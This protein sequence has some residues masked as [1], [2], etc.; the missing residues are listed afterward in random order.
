M[1][2]LYGVVGE[3]MGHAMRSA[4]LLEALTQAGHELRIVGSGRAAAYLEQRY[5]E[6]TTPITGLELVYEDNAVH[7]LKTAFKN[8]KSIKDVPKN[9]RRYAEMARDYSPDVVVSDFESWTYWFARGQRIPVIS[10]DNMQI[11]AR[12]HHPDRIVWSKM[13][14]FLLVKNIVRSKLPSC[15]HYLITTFFYPRVKRDRTTLHPPVLRKIILNAKTQVNNGE[16]ILVYQTGTSHDA[17]VEELK[18][19]DVP[20]RVYG[21]RRDLKAPVTEDNLTFCPF[22]EAGFIK[23]LATSRGVIAGGGFTLLG[24]AFYLG[25]PVLSVPIAGQFEQTL[26]ATYLADLGYGDWTDQ[27]AAHKIRRFLQHLPEYQEKLSTF[28]HDDNAG[29]INTLREKLEEAVAEGPRN[30]A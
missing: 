4:V 7:K 28:E 6:Q 3:G 17:L 10:V 27:I 21:L 14:N 19:V 15:N 13:S 5:P 8:L 12:C 23:D 22:S 1:R 25:K 11:I 2:I 18:K 20:M 29:L 16:H 26:N 9:F 24:E 30:D